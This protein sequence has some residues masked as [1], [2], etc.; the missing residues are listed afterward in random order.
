MIQKMHIYLKS[1][2]KPF[3]LTEV[4][5]ENLRKIYNYIEIIEISDRESLLSE[6][7]EIEYLVTWEFKAEWYA[8]AKQLK[9]VFTPAAGSDWA[10]EDPSGK[11]PLYHGAF[12]GRMIAESLLSAMLYFNRLMPTLLEKQKKREW[13]RNF[14]AGTTLLC[15][16]K[17]MIV[18]Y[19]SIGNECAELLH[20]MGCTVIGVKRSGI[21]GVDSRGTILIGKNEMVEFLPECNHL[22][23]VLP[24]GQSTNGFI[25][26]KHLDLLPEEACIYNVGRGNCISENDIIDIVES[27][28]IRGA[29]LDVFEEEPLPKKSSLWNI[30][31]ILITPHA[32][33]AYREYGIL[34]VHELKNLLRDLE[35]VDSSM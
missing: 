35:L 25:S 3:H 32:S 4:V 29:W 22:V 30:P 7:D 6:L 18:G 5:S 10:D 1:R 21:G 2:D 23:L 9:A 34:Y 14:Q 12:H 26:R 17:V 28:K 15:N 19:G 24:G 27:R 20:H 33:C 8:G 16:Q 11:V 13:D 31:G